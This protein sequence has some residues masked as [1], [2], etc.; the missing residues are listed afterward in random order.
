MRS[1][2][3]QWDPIEHTTRAWGMTGV[4]E[5]RGDREEG[6]EKLFEERMAPKLPTFDEKHSITYL[7]SSVNSKLDKL[8]WIPNS[9]T[10]QRENLEST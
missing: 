10:L 4:P 9:Q 2:I 5:K 6:T 7:R 3:G 1:D 8:I